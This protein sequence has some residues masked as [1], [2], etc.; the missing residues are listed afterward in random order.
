MNKLDAL[1]HECWITW[2]MPDNLEVGSEVE[3]LRCH[4]DM[5]I[6]EITEGLGEN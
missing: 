4:E 3:C 5:V 6:R 2:A 1:C